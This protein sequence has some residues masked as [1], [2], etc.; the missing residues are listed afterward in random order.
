MCFGALV[1]FWWDLLGFLIIGMILKVSVIFIDDLGWGWL[2]GEILSWIESVLGD[3]FTYFAS[4][5]RPYS[6]ND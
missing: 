5:S 6:P 1:G 2:I 4:K 3:L